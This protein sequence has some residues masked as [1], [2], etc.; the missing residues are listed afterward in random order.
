MSPSPSSKPAPPDFTS[1]STPD[2]SLTNS[3]ST[4]KGITAF[5][6]RFG[7]QNQ[8]HFTG[9]NLDQLEFKDTNESLYYPL[10]LNILNAPTILIDVFPFIFL[11]SSQFLLI[12]LTDL[13]KN[14]LL[15]FNFN[16]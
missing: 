1:T 6:V 4:S 9:I 2:N 10:L 8:S 3:N 12:N 16:I 11:I 15:V 14:L 7:A 13:L 5:K